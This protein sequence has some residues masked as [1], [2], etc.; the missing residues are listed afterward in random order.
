MNTNFHSVLRVNR[1]KAQAKASYDRLSAIYD[2]FA[3]FEQ[4]ARNLGLKRLDIQPGETVLEIGS[5]TGHCLITI[6]EIVG[7]GGRV[8][9]LDLSSGMLRVSQRWLGKAGFRRR[10][11]L[12]CGDA[13]QLPYPEDQFDAIFMS[14]T[15]ELFDT[16][17]IPRVL[18]EIQRILKPGGRIGV[19]SMSK[20]DGHSWLL[21]FY[22]W[23]HL[24]FPRYADCRPIYVEQ[25]IREAGFEIR[26][27]ERIILWDLPGEIVVGLKSP[28]RV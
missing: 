19:I 11:A 7:E 22:E 3:F 15:L 13:C 16:P 17:E 9:G 24:K 4:G 8:N 20:E 18:A 2:L 5:G 25:S 27:K 1:T 23:F 14:F 12:T 26:H 6:A 10:V 28:Q 21:R